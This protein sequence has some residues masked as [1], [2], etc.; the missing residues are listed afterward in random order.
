[1]HATQNH[2]SR[3][4]ATPRHSRP[5]LQVRLYQSAS[6]DQVIVSLVGTPVAIAGM[7][8]V[9]G[10]VAS[11]IAVRRPRPGETV[12]GIY[13]HYLDLTCASRAGGRS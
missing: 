5:A 11:V 3:M 4:H 12:D 7:L 10:A 6:G 1:M 9:L 13:V 2:P 8:R